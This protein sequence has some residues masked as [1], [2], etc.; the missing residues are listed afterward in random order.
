[1][2][3]DVGTRRTRRRLVRTSRN[4]GSYELRSATI[5]STVPP[6][7]VSLKPTQLASQ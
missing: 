7:A 4:D 6:P 3:A 5:R 2:T 1:M